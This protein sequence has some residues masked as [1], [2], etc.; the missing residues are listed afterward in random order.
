MIFDTKKNTFIYN[1]FDFKYHNLLPKELY[2]D[3]FLIQN[4]NSIIW[5]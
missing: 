1:Y 2:I 5:S 3:W 4:K